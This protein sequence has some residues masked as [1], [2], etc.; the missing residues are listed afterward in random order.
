MKIYV[1]FIVFEGISKT[2]PFIFFLSDFKMGTVIICEVERGG[3][4]GKFL[5]WFPAS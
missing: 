3:Q 1:H 2:F 4:G 5:S